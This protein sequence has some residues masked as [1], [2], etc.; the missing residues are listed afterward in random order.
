LDT[1]LSAITDLSLRNR[2]IY[3]VAEMKAS[4][5]LD[6]EFIERANMS[7]TARYRIFIEFDCA[8]VPLPP[9]SGDL[10]SQGLA[11]ME[12]SLRTALLSHTR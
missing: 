4:I 2:I 9:V 10:V 12:H 1:L 5:R 3:R 6:D 11:P 7:R 8:D